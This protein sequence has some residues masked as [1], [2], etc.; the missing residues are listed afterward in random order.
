MYSRVS[1]DAPVTA[2]ANPHAAAADVEVRFRGRHPEINADRGVIGVGIDRGALSYSFERPRLRQWMFRE[3]FGNLGP[4]FI[5]DL[6]QQRTGKAV[7]QIGGYKSANVTEVVPDCAF[8]KVA[9][10]EFEGARR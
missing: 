3:Q 8:Q 1:W 4:Q 6:E 10:K 9:P 5:D 2:R 7:L